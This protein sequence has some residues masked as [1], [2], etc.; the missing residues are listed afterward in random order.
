MLKDLEAAEYFE[1]MKN[2]TITVF[3]DEGLYRHIR[4]AKGNSWNDQFDIVTWPGY[5]SYSGDLGDYTF[6]RIE[7]MFKFF[8]GHEQQPNFY[9]WAEKLQAV[10][11]RGGYEEFSKIKFEQNIRENFKEWEFDNKEQRDLAWEDIEDIFLR[12]FD[13]ETDAKTELHRYQCPWGGHEFID[14]WEWDVRDYTFSYKLACYGIPWAIGRYDEYKLR[15]AHS[16][17]P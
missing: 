4:M 17:Y 15:Q 13:S 16:C 11:K 2:H 7:D 1:R 12:G 10:D 14:S 6:E 9:Y 8:R 5:L 3:H